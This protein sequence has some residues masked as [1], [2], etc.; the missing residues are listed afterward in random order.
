MPT[1]YDPDDEDFQDDTYS[2]TRNRRSSIG[3]STNFIA[4]S[5]S[6]HLSE[7]R[8]V[9][10]KSTRDDSSAPQRKKREFGE[11]SKKKAGQHLQQRQDFHQQLPVDAFYTADT[12][13]SQPDTKRSQPD[14]ISIDD[15]G[16]ESENTDASASGRSP[17]HRKR[18]R[19]SFPRK[20]I[21]DDEWK[22]GYDERGNV[23][24]EESGAGET[25][26]SPYKKQDGDSSGRGRSEGLGGVS[27]SWESVLVSPNSPKSVR[28]KRQPFL[29]NFEGGNGSVEV[30]SQSSAIS[31]PTG[32]DKL[33]T[34]HT[35]DWR[36]N[37]V[38][39]YE[40]QTAGT[41]RSSPFF[42]VERNEMSS[43]YSAEA[44]VVSADRK[45]STSRKK[46]AIDDASSSDDEKRE[47]MQSMR[48]RPTIDLTA[49]EEG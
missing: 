46:S 44:L 24:A 42:H 5:K 23:G 48:N 12:K 11:A 38:D 9:A 22:P 8:L 14:T 34:S 30:L 32:S 2:N 43:S 26:L 4:D 15:S 40:L 6:G 3:T 39:A 1:S 37:L 45:M 13:R 25:E 41:E 20:D 21:G 49:E 19:K 47:N 35:G 31:E 7:S 29:A 36:P 33:S 27:K 16:S 18:S 28:E 17:V 10:A